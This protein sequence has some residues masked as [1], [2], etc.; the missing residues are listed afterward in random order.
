M[1]DWDEKLI[2]TVH[3]TW[4][5]DNESY[6]S[7]TGYTLNEQKVIEAAKHHNMLQNNYTQ[8]LECQF[9]VKGQGKGNKKI[10]LR[11]QY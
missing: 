9:I 10:I 4:H 5:D 6:S 2:I 3:M 8:N 7:N 11:S 1:T